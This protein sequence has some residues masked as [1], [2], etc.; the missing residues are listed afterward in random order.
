MTVSADTLD[1]RTRAFVDGE[2]V[3]AAS[4]A[5]FDCVSPRSGSVIAAVA[6]CDSVDVDAPCAAPAPRS[7]PAL[8]RGR[9]RPCASGF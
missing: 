4:G 5:T 3:D 8:G 6:A 2:Y 9:R 1:I 7:S